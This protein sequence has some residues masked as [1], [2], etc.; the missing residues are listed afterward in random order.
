LNA[1][2]LDSGTE[3]KPGYMRRQLRQ[4]VGLFDIGLW[5]AQH[6]NSAAKG[7]NV[8]V[9]AMVCEWRCRS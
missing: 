9:L 5:H 6:E 2:E 1:G 8:I 4:H 3:N 7:I